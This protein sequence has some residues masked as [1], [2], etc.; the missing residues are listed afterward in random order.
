MLALAALLPALAARWLVAPAVM[1][2]RAHATRG[3]L[4]QR[5]SCTQLACAIDPARLSAC[6]EQG[7]QE[8]T[9]AVSRAWSEICDAHSAT[10][11]ALKQS[12]KAAILATDGKCFARDCNGIMHHVTSLQLYVL[13]HGHASL[14]PKEP[15]VMSL[16]DASAV[17]LLCL[18]PLASIGWAQRAIVHS[19]LSFRPSYGPWCGGVLFSAPTPTHAF[20]DNKSAVPVSDLQANA[21]RE[22]RCV[23]VVASRMASLRPPPP[24]SIVHQPHQR[25]RWQAMD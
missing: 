5:S 2:V 17:V 19:L 21:R 24:L 16:L 3:L 6:V 13:R 23:S 14:L 9:L 11:L 4:P 1:R 8:S 7:L 10:Q 18:T 22:Q 15:L 20:C 12:V 25:P